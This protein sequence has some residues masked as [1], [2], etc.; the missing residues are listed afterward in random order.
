MRRDI[1]K[2]VKEQIRQIKYD[3]AWTRRQVNMLTREAAREK[4]W[5]VRRSIQSK[6]TMYLSEDWT[7]NFYVIYQDGSSWSGNDHDFW[8][9]NNTP[10]MQHIVYARMS[11]GYGDIDTESGDLSFPSSDAGA[12]AEDDYMGKIEALY[13]G[14]RVDAE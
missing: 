13:L 7:E 9:S 14:R 8:D 10:K 6:I 4:D 3:V 1:L 11:D 2:R 5:R 12:E